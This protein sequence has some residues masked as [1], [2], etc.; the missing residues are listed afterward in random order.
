MN[1]KKKCENCANV[2][3]CRH[4]QEEEFTCYCDNY[5]YFRPTE[6]LIRRDERNK[7]VNKFKTLA[8]KELLELIDGQIEFL[9]ML[10]VQHGD[11]L[12]EALCVLIDHQINK[13]KQDK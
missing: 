6:K 1:I 13:L 9:S 4:I 8:N 3:Y 10:I 11:I 5:K 2:K 7:C 12:G